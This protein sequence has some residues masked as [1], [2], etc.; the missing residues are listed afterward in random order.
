MATETTIVREAPFVEE[1]RQDLL[2]S[3]AAL[4]DQPVTVPQ[5]QLAPTS[6]TTTQAYKYAGYLRYFK[7]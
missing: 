3:A 7:R 4:A 1:A 2:T 5:V 6:D